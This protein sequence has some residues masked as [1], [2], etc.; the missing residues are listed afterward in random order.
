M[1]PDEYHRDSVIGGPGAFLVV[2]EE[3]KSFGVAVRSSLLVMAAVITV[4]S[5][6]VVVILG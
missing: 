5:S 4:K 3:F 2:A 1:R 6:K